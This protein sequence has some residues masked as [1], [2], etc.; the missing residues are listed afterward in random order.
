[1]KG[2]GQNFL[3]LK[4][5][6]FVVQN[7]HISALRVYITSSLTMI[8][9]SLIVPSLLPIPFFQIF[10]EIIPISVDLGNFTSIS[11]Q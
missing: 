5:E 9:N 3:Q 2:L 8:L 10:T 4:F 7:K 1:M 11:H 6:K